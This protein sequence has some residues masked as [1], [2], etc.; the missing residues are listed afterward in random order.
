MW[1]NTVAQNCLHYL[2]AQGT[3][4]NVRRIIIKNYGGKFSGYRGHGVVV[5]WKYHFRDSN[6][7]VRF[8][9]DEQ[10]ERRVEVFVDGKPAAII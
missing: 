10:E 5:F 7:S 4:D 3:P 1:N 9:R 2:K 8:F 6:I